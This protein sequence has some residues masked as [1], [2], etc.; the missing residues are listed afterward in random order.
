MANK[1]TKSSS[2]FNLKVE[3]LKPHQ[4]PVDIT[5]S[6]DRFHLVYSKEEIFPHIELGINT[7]TAKIQRYGIGFFSEKYQIT[8]E[9][10]D[11][12]KK[13]LVD[14]FTILG[15]PIRYPNLDL[16]MI[17]RMIDSKNPDA[18]SGEVKFSILLIN[19]VTEQM[20]FSKAF[21]WEKPV[22]YKDILK[23]VMDSMPVWYEH[24]KPDYPNIMFDQFFIPYDRMYNTFAYVLTKGYF[25]DYHS[26]CFIMSHNGLRLYNLKKSKNRKILKTTIFPDAKQIKDLDGI[27]VIDFNIDRKPDLK[28]KYG[29][30]LQTIGVGHFKGDTIIQSGGFEITNDA[31]NKSMFK[32]IPSQNLE[33]HNFGLKNKVITN[34]AITAMSD[35]NDLTIT[36][37]RWSSFEYLM[38]LKHI[39]DIKFSA[40]LLDR[41]SGKYFINSV[42]LIVER[43]K[44]EF[45]PR[46]NAS[47]RML[48]E[49][50][51]KKTE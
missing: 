38:P 46:I 2:F 10:Y 32:N 27:F 7:N 40:Q 21:V 50:I 23:K 43:Q 33:Y 14:T 24:D 48:G 42:E 1:F 22:K 17:S 3:L 28:L 11:N 20:F 5:D 34:S 36:I 35:M 47:L 37:N 31:F 51:M 18:N 45:V 4:K 49:N 39:Y 19:E 13:N 26:I 16:K 12:S 8:V 25:A 29:S 9:L 15:K 41:Y 6:V 30:R 44:Q